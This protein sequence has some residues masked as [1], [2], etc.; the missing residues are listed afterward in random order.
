[1]EATRFMRI[2]F[3]VTGY[4]I[5]EDNMEDIARW[6]QGHVIHGADDSFVRVPVYRAAHPRQTEGR[7]G[8]WVIVSIQ[9]GRRSFKVYTDEWL[10]KQFIEIPTEPVDE[11]IPDVSFEERTGKT[12]SIPVNPLP[13]NVLPIPGQREVGA[14]SQNITARNFAPRAR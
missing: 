13:D 12:R 10:R 5:T 3:F 9:R 1:M 7:V 11:G 4:Q 2:P 14:V 8:E 6:C